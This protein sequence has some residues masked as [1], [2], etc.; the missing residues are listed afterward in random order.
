MPE[1]IALAGVTLVRRTQEEL[2]YDL[3]RT[4]MNVLRAPRGRLKRKTVIDG[5]DLRIQ[6]G[7]KVGII[8]P[9]GSGKSTLLKLIAGVL[10]PTKGTVAVDG[11]VAPLIE[12][13]VGFDP[14]LTLVDNIVFYGVLLGHDERLVREHVDAILDFAE[15]GEIRDQP[16]K[17]LSSGM[18]ARLGFAIATEFRP[19]ILLL[20]EVLAV[21]DEHFRRKCGTRIERFWDAHSTIVLVSH[22][23]N[24]VVRTCDRIIWVDGGAIRFDGRPET[25]VQRYLE[26]VP[27]SLDIR[28]GEELIALAATAHLPVVVRGAARNGFDIDMFLVRNGYRWRI[29]PDGEYRRKAVM[30]ENVMVVSDAVIEQVPEGDAVL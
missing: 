27:P 8:G 14:G 16:T 2:H 28:S 23:L 22:D 9:N 10:R 19:E 12:I 1:A 5:V 30:W 13:G 15:L 3:K 26:T 7:E 17:T 4:L 6:H 20:D 24:Y 25:A 29:A 21:G 18:S 11:S